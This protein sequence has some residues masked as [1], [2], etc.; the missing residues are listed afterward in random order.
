MA[1]YTDAAAAGAALLPPGVV[2]EF[3]QVPTAG[4]AT[5]PLL[6]A[7]F[8]GATT[9]YRAPIDVT[10]WHAVLVRE[11]APASQY[12]ALIQLLRSGVAVPDRVAC[13]A[14][15]GTGMH[16]FRGRAWSALEGNIHLTVHF[17][18]A[19]RIERFE[20][21]FTALAAVAAAEAAESVPDLRG[22]VQIKWVNDVLVDS[23]KVGGVLA[24]TQTREDVMTAV[25]LGIGLNVEATP[26]VERS[27]YVPAASCLRDAAPAPLAVTADAVLHALLDALLRNYALL[28]EEGPAPLL[29]AYRARSAVLGEV[30]TVVG[31]DASASEIVATGRVAAIGDGL[32]LYI[33][34]HAAPVTRGRLLL[35]VRP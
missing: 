17:T 1:I 35:G 30:V 26:V 12:D 32:E 16:G 2:G 22:R 11:H 19:R 4:E 18:P 6:R 33:E 13:A 34:G 29:G 9:V 28:L 27:L 31:D 20:S 24:Y 23:M 3:T 5:A 14:R 10:G 15:A 8:D 21:A 7:L 25:V